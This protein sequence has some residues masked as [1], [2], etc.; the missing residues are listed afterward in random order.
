MYYGWSTYIPPL[1][2]R[3][4]QPALFLGGGLTLGGGKFVDY[5][6]LEPQWP[7]FLKVNLQKS[8]AIFQQ[9]QMLFGF[10]VYYIYIY[11]YYEVYLAYIKQSS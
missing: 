7:L 6:C 2:I 4:K 9:K 11:I 10:Q 1:E 8:K 3:S 5:K